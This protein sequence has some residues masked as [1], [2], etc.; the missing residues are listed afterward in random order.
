MRMDRTL[1]VSLLAWY[2]A[3]QRDLPWR[4][5]RD[6][7]R[8]WISEIMLQQT[9]VDTVIDYY[10]RFLDTFPTVEDLAKADLEVVLK[11]WEGLGYYRRARLLHQ[12]AMIIV[13]QHQ[14]RFPRSVEEIEKLPGIGHYT[15]GAIASIAFEQQALAIDGNVL[16]VLSRMEADPLDGTATTV[17][18][19]AT[20]ILEP[21]LPLE[22]RGDFSQAFMELG[23]TVCLPNGTP[24]CPVCPWQKSCLAHQQGNP[25]DYPKKEKSKPRPIYHYH[26]WMMEHQGRFALVRRPEKGVLAG[27]WQFPLTTMEEGEEPPIHGVVIQLQA[28]GEYRHIFSHMEWILHVKRVCFDTIESNPFTWKTINDIQET[29]ALP[30]AFQPAWERI[31]QRNRTE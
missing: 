10:T 7:Y 14:G 31:L 22:Q 21:L 8:I 18:K 12:A 11:M 1:T 9:R 3:N 24:R 6:P 20:R 26:L 16:R 17:I 29:I 19:K 13:E 15:A 28:E 4:H 25:L 27:M 2:Q 23:A 5:T 30:T